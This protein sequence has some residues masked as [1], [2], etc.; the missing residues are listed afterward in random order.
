MPM[1]ESESKQ[2]VVFKLGREEYGFDVSTVREIQ[3]MDQI[4][5]VHGSVG[6]VEGVM[7]LRGKLVTIIDMRK[8]FGMG[9]PTE[10][11]E[12][13]IVVIDAPDAPVGF[14]VDEV[15]EVIHI[16]KDSVEDVPTPIA[17]KI[18]SE[19]V[20]GIAKRDDRLITLVDPIK[21]LDLSVGSE[22]GPRRS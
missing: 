8:R 17:S 22:A 6:Y 7:N 13:K 16:S 14:I 3:S 2:Y 15:T 10:K 19:Y 9:P 11:T 1:V 5:A 12:T 20:L 4:T 21:I 18:E